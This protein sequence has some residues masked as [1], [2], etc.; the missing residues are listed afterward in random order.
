MKV[1]YEAGLSDDVAQAV[2]SVLSTLQGLSQQEIATVL[3]VVQERL[4]LKATQM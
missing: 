2:V 1:K 4:G 3:Q